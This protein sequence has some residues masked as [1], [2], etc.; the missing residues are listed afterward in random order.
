MTGQDR[1]AET[2]VMVEE[3][4]RRNR[5]VADGDPRLVLLGHLDWLIAEIER[6]R[7][8]LGKLE[9]V[10]SPNETIRC[11]RICLAME[12]EGHFDGCALA[13]ALKST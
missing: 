9:W 1:L 2:K 3:I 11:C 13:D 8:L 5:L 7:G 10:P 6:L 4:R 12:H